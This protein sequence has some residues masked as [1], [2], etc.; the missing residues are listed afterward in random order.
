LQQR[1]TPAAIYHQGLPL[2]TGIC[3]ECVRA[4]QSELETEMDYFPMVDQTWESTDAA[5]AGFDPAKLAAAIAIAETHETSW[6]YDLED[7]GN[8]PGLSQFEKAPWNE[9]L[10]VFKP[11]G[12]PNGLLLRGGRIVGRWG[13]PTRVEMTFS[14]AKSYLA[15]LAG[16]AVGDGLIGNIDGPVA[17]S[18]TAS[19]FASQR[20]RAITWRHLLTQT[21]EWEGTLFD[22]PDLVDRNRQVGPGTDNSRKGEHRDLCEP[23]AYWEYNDVRVNV[24]ALA[25]MHV[26]RRPL[27]EVLKERIMDPI[28]T[29]ADWRWHGYRNSYIEIDGQRMQS[30]PGGTH[31]GGGIHIS[32]FDHARFGLLV[33]RGGVW[34]GRLLLPEGWVDA[35]RAPSSV[36]DGYGFLWW[37]NTGHHEWPAASESA[38]AAVG[39]GTNIILIDPQFDLILVARLIDQNAVNGLIANVVDAIV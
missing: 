19:E 8:V 3:C 22:K 4:R 20:N 14:I 32:S 28:G 33:H 10:G 39:A 7:A 37:L 31:W 29:S 15:C 5:A 12:R 21:S 35:L 1:K 17:D 13:D 18:V 34:G 25:L 38:Y 26:F 30:V 36:N 16:I 23:G 24:L 27:P 2:V 11:R 9:A 6:P